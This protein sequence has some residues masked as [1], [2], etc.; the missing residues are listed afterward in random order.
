MINTI[1]IRLAGLTLKW[2]LIFGVGLGGLYYFMLFN[3]GSTIEVQIQKV[4]KEIQEQETK[5]KESD[6]A[7]K[8]VEK[9]RAEVG[10]LSDQF[11]MV[12]QV[13][14]AEVQMQDIIRAV[15]TTARASGVS[16][17][18][19]EPR[20]SVNHGYYE[21]IP[22]HI[23]MDGSFAEITMFLFYMASQERIMKVKNFVLSQPQQNEKVPLGRLLFDGQ[24]VT[25]RF[26]VEKVEKKETS[27]K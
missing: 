21:E 16:I 24:V 3:D 11:K 23:S 27:K 19:K 18:T 4:Q 6:A 14:P 5:E 15:D 1:L 26:I 20:P 8:E 7:L 13:L 17:K 12:S 9:I 22:L 10:A 25:Y 2:A